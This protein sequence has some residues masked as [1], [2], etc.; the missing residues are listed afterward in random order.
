MRLR[1]PRPDSWPSARPPGAAS[2]LRPSEAHPIVGLE[3]AFADPGKLHAARG[4]RWTHV[5]VPHS[6]TAS[7][8]ARDAGRRGAWDKA[9]SVPNAVTDIK[10]CQKTL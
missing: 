2:E 6:P 5:P 10:K 8:L 3:A 9:K 7:V 4:A 1:G